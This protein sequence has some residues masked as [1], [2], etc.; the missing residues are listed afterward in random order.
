MSPC[1]LSS[2]PCSC[3]LD[4][5]VYITF[6]SLRELPECDH[7]CVLPVTLCTSFLSSCMCILYHHV[8]QY[9]THVCLVHGVLPAGM[10]WQSLLWRLLASSAKGLWRSPLPVLSPQSPR[11]V[12]MLMQVSP[13]LFAL[14]SS[15]THTVQC[16]EV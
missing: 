14:H 9:V 10:P 7:V 3:Y 13:L 2:C 11:Q 12:S 8:W 16:V 4:V 15:A 5:A 6:M 1:M